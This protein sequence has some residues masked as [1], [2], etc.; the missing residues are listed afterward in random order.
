VSLSSAEPM[1]Q[2]VQKL[3]PDLMGLMVALRAGL[4]RSAPGPG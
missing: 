2:V 3:A 1:P 4:E